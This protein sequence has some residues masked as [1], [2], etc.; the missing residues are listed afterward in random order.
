MSIVAY[1]VTYFTNEF[2][3]NADRLA[4]KKKFRRLPDQISSLI[5]ELESGSLDGDIIFHSDVPPY[6]IYK[7]R[8]PNEDAKVGKSG[9]YRVIYLARHDNMTIAFLLIY[10]KKEQE[11]ASDA[12]IKALTDGYLLDAVPEAD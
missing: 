5:V 6:D 2:E 11:S 12:L 7:V 8:L 9:G 10:Y 1:E 4:V 3:K